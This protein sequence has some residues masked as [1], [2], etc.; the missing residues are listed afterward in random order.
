MKKGY[1]ERVKEWI[2]A[3][4]NPELDAPADPGEAAF[5]NAKNVQG[6]SLTTETI[7]FAWYEDAERHRLRVLES[8][9]DAAAA[10]SCHTVHV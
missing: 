4:L 3:C 1:L 6:K 7:G 9:K 10:S 8:L 5:L 2:A